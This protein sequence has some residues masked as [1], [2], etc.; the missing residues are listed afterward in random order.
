MCTSAKGCLLFMETHESLFI[1]G[2]SEEVLV[3]AI[4]TKFLMLPPPT[5][6]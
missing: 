5:G 3:V 6:D 4:A 1:R 2:S